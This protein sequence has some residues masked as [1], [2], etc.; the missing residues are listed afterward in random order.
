MPMERALYVRLALAA[1]LA[2]PLA[3]TQA[4]T[5]TVD[6]TENHPWTEACERWDDWDK[7]GPA[8][9]IHGNTW[10]VGTCGIA[11]IL[12]TSDEG[13]VL[14]DSGTEKGA[15]IV[16]SNIRSIGIDAK[17]IRLLLTSHEHFDHVGGM[18]TLQ[19]ATGAEV[20]SST[21]GIF[22]LT[23]SKDH[24]EDPQFGMHEPMIPIAHGLTYDSAEGAA[25]LERFG[26]TAVPTPGHTPG[27][28][29]WTWTSCEP[30]GECRSMVYADSLSPVSADDYRFTDHPEYLRNY[31]KSLDTVAQLDCDMLL[32]PHPSAAGLHDL[33]TRKWHGFD[34]PTFACM[35][36]AREIRTR[37]SIRLAEEAA[38]Q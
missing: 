4:Q 16:L 37:L 19:E 11:A 13:H 1:L 34:E 24:P 8:F 7:P 23:R 35:G 17:D 26:M 38:A 2:L 15:E 30:G 25:L 5:I 10:Y 20:I 9:N 3:G 32:T 6:Q 12:I 14:I 31:M 36:Y 21:P 28:M 22:V 33:L 29:S 18:A 27:A